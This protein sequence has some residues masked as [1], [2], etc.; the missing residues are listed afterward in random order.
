MLVG[1]KK[2]PFVTATFHRSHHGFAP[3]ANVAATGQPKMAYLDV[4]KNNKNKSSQRIWIIF[5][6]MATFVSQEVGNVSVQ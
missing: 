1:L 6:R 4:E 3:E 2:R 5:K